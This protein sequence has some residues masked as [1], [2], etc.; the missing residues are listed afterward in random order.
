MQTTT[1]PGSSHWPDVVF[2]VARLSDAARETLVQ[3]H[4]TRYGT[5]ATR[6]VADELARAGFVTVE[7]AHHG[8]VADG[9]PAKLATAGL[10]GE[11]A[12]AVALN[13]SVAR[14][15]VPFTDAGAS[16]ATQLGRPVTVGSRVG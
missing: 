13:L 12:A 1:P 16:P 5:I 14:G 11:R 7:P 15:A 6:R 10:R 8:D 4:D 3:C 2:D 9:F